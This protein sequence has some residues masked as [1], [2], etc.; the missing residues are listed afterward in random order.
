MIEK[1]SE[2]RTVHKNIRIEENEIHYSE[3]NQE[4]YALKDCRNVQIKENKENL[5]LR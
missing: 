4:L 1:A 3:K 2:E 5:T